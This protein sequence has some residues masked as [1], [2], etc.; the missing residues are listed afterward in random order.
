[1]KLAD[2]YLKDLNMSTYFIK[3][4]IEHTEALDVGMARINKKRVSYLDGGRRQTLH[5]IDGVSRTTGGAI[6]AVIDAARMENLEIKTK[7]IIT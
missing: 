1:M 7:T 4:K 5:S 2:N 6:P 3:P